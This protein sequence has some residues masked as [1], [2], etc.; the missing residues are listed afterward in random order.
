MD[1]FID[2]MLNTPR[3]GSTRNNPT[4]PE[5]PLPP[6]P[7]PTKIKKST[8]AI[9][10]RNMK[11]VSSPAA[12][13]LPDTPA[14]P[15]IRLQAGPSAPQAA[16]PSVRSSTPAHVT[17][18]E[19][20][21]FTA[22]EL[23][24]P[25]S[26]T[27]GPP[28]PG[29]FTPTSE[30]AVAPPGLP[31]LARESPF[32]A[33][34]TGEPSAAAKEHKLV[35]QPEEQSDATKDSYEDGLGSPPPVLQL[36]RTQTPAVQSRSAVM[37]GLSGAPA[38]GKT[39][40]AHLLA[41]I[42]PPSTPSF[43]IHQDDFFVRKHLLIPGA[44][45]EIGVDYR[46]T[47]DFSALKQLM[48]YSKEE[49]QLP[50]GFRS[51]QPEENRERALSRISPELIE[52]MR[53]SLASLP[54]LRDGQS[55]GIVDGFMLFHSETI[56][57]MLDVKIL[58]R[59]SKQVSKSRREEHAK[60]VDGPAGKIGH[61]WETLDYFDR[62]LWPNYVE[63]HAVLFEDRVVEGS[64]VSDVCEG[65]GI[66]VQPKLVMSVEEVLHWVAEVLRRKCGEDGVRQERGLPSPV[67][68][69]GDFEHCDC[70]EGLLGKLRRIIFDLV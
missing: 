8:N 58:L 64:P 19:S 42:L 4:S 27:R 53:A 60:D 48:S 30:L 7:A 6:S 14:P 57:D 10:L 44:D 13:P 37:I 15:P 67:E 16:Q 69:K 35:A 39:T 22:A 41:A 24:P 32:A 33:S 65:V 59:A 38:S 20:G 49:G 56:R 11:D 62:V 25:A 70:D 66:A 55:V 26:G 21:Y 17:K 2:D 9:P 36:V 23:A 63:E 47:V 50:P 46:R 61:P 68:R 18:A 45:G 54:S 52:N 40:L 1:Y 43:I 34:E 31:T 28:V 12:V 51:L 29:A 3:R 5:P